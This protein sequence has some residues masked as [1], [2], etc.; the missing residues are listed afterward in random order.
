MDKLEKDGDAKNRFMLIGSD[1]PEEGGKKG[2]N[3]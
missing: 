2:I 3:F 1:F